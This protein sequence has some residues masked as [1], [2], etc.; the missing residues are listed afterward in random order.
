MDQEIIQTPLLSSLEKHT[1][2]RCRPLWISISALTLI[3][4]VSFAVIEDGNSSSKFQ[5]SNVGDK[6]NKYGQGK[7][8]TE[9]EQNEEV[10]ESEHGVVAADD[11]R[12]SEI[13]VQML[14]EGGHAVD[15]AV[16]T[17][18]CLGVVYPMAS[19]IGGG[20]FMVVRSAL[21]RKSQAFDSREIAP[22]AA[23]QDM[24][25][26]NPIGKS[27]GAMSMGVPGEIAGLHEA[28]LRHGRLPWR[29]LFQPAI[30]LA[31]DGFSVSIYL[32]LGIKKSESKIMSDPVGL[33]QVFAPKGNLLR[34]GDT[35]Y[36]I[37]L[38]HSLEMIANQ[39]PK[40]FYNGPLGAK[41]IKDVKKA[42]GIVSMHDLRNYKVEVTD[43]M[44]VDVF[45]FTI[46]GMPPPSS[47]TL[48]LSMVCEY[49]VLFFL[50]FYFK[51][52]FLLHTFKFWICNSFPFQM[53]DIEHLELVNQA[54][55]IL[56]SYGSLDFIKGS[57]GLHRLIEAIKHMLAFRMNLGDPKFVNTTKYES[58]MLSPSFAARIRRKIVDNTTFPP[59]YYMHKWNQLD[60]H[61]TSHLCIVDAERNAVSMTST[62]NSYFGAGVLSPSTGIVLNNE[63]NDFSVPTE[64]SEFKLPPAP[65]N[66]IEPNKRPLSSMTPIIILKDNQLAG[67]IGGSGGL[68]IIPAVVQVFLN[69]FVIGMEP[70][71]AIQHPRV[72][73][74]VIPNV[75][76]YENWT[77]IDGE[78][79]EVSEEK[80]SFLKERGHMLVGR[81]TGAICQLVVQ[82]LGSPIEKEKKA[83]GME[84]IH[85][86]EDENQEVF[87]GMLTA[88]SDP[89]KN[90][91]P[92][93]V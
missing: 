54:L 45:G 55:N 80:R 39:G 59:N 27:L 10:V 32:E 37:E 89:R 29:K 66:F 49:L 8:T 25:A 17:C 92:A 43:A 62:V 14:R 83:T 2:N 13:G 51:F 65:S 61:G 67:V 44:A 20:G 9:K 48:G 75:V 34:A 87:H 57:L 40:A 38:A 31:K 46:I 15:A 64:I 93:A 70:L 1:R 42:G 21:T 63:M 79:I 47:G 30:K 85:V 53:M 84:R 7:A 86:N 41:F 4:I 6:Y 19:G 58:D 3:F 68:Y 50:V 23:T 82:N 71:A 12:C 26:K 36:N 81:P 69:H 91:R 16:A 56:S 90:G 60:D 33:G 52:S 28:W 11:G 18:L 78:H 72:Y 35:C 22:L 24:Y 77:V 88:V 76:L 5:K 74:L 73:H